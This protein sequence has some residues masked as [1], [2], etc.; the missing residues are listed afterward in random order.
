M[1]GVRVYTI[2]ED[3]LTAKELAGDFITPIGEVWN[4][5]IMGWKHECQYCGTVFYS[6]RRRAKYCSGKHRTYAGRERK[7]EAEMHHC[8]ICDRPVAKRQTT[9]SPKCR[10]K[11]Y[12]KRQLNK[13]RK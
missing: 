1:V 13:L 11:L 2:L 10:Q 8:R 6:E 9:C 4:T 12:R 5:E 7:R 3:E